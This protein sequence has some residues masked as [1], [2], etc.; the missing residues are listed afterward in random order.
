MTRSNKEDAKFQ[1][2]CMQAQMRRGYIWRISSSIMRRIC[3]LR[4][5]Q[6]LGLRQRLKS[7]MNPS[8]HFQDCKGG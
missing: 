1:S 4:L 6:I 2:K 7:A 3:M 8:W 5:L